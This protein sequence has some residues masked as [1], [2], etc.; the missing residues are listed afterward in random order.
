MNLMNLMNL[1]RSPSSASSMGGADQ[2][3]IPV[4]Q[5]KAVNL[6]PPPRLER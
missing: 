6:D 3:S 4:L 1:T 5:Q 2:R